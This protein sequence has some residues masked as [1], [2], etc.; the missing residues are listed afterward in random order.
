MK[1]NQAEYIQDLV[2][3]ANEIYGLTEQGK[4]LDK[5]AE[6]LKQLKDKVF[7]YRVSLSEDTEDFE[8]KYHKWWSVKARFRR[9][10][11]LFD[12]GAPAII[13]L[14]E[15]DWLK[16]EIHYLEQIHQGLEPCYTQDEL[17]ELESLAQLERDIEEEKKNNGYIENE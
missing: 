10:N 3:L 5:S 16:I 8:K 6:L 9:S 11:R 13:I 17:D 4:H 14:H 15:L 7:L 12:L 2:H 1:E